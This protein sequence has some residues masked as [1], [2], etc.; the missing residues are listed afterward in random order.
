MPNF[1]IAL[2]GLEA[3]SIA[4]NTIGNNLANLNTTAYKGQSTTFE[5][6]FYQQIGTSGSNDP[7]QVGVGTRVSGTATSFAQGTI[8]TS[9]NSTDMSLS[10]DGF[11]VVQQGGVQSLTRAGNFQL[12]SVGNLTTING[13]SVMGFPSVGGA[14]GKSS[15]LA[16][17]TLPVGETQSAQATQNVSISTNL[18]ASAAVGAQFQTP[19]TVYDTLGQSHVATVT[20]TKASAT[21]W[22]YAVTLPAA[23]ETG[24]PTGNTGTLTFDS[25]G[26][27]VTPAANVAGVTFPGMADG[28]SSMNFSLNLYNAGGVATV[29]QS[30]LA[31][32][33]VTSNQDG[34]PA[35]TYQSFK[36]DAQGIV[37]ASFSNGNSAL[38]GQVAV[39]SVNNDN[40]LTR[41]G[42]NNFQ[43]T[44]A[45]GASTIGVA[46]TGGR[47]TI[48]DDSLEQ[49]NVDISTEFSNL[50]V[51]Q[52]AFEANSKTVTTFD[53]VTQDAI[54]MIR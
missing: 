20:Y 41:T 14:V 17:L 54:S 45:S 24:T 43:T 23:D 7:V 8:S 36:V 49:S 25:T 18:D 9:A 46:G 51:A 5:D 42:D 28:A 13:E 32:N 21:S 30:A 16:P 22:G 29:G 50:I 4:L 15:T 44:A 2:T 37:S 3:N 52:R 1:S 34:F 33:N 12:D 26:K 47:A 39:A 48:E 11:F 53:T 10:G 6:L 40:G 31:S 19:V 35:G 38:I 27:L